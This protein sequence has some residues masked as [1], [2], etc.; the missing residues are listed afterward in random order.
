MFITATVFAG[1]KDLDKIYMTA[2]AFYLGHF[3]SSQFTDVLDRFDEQRE[4]MEHPFSDNTL[5]WNIRWFDM[6]LGFYRG[7]LSYEMGWH[8]R[9]YYLDAWNLFDTGSNDP[10]AQ[11]LRVKMTAVYSGVGL[12]LLHGFVTPAVTLEAGKLQISTYA[13][14]KSLKY[15]RRGRRFYDH[16]DEGVDEWMAYLNL[17]V[18]IM[19]PT[20][21]EEVFIKVEPYYLMGM[22]TV[23]LAR[24]SQSLTPGLPVDNPNWKPEVYGVMISYAIFF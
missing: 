2:P 3:P 5:T 13:E 18:K 8:T 19:I 6:G 14:D 10:T 21:W 20:G 7:F 4:W 24:L 17:S 16:L 1:P 23:S 15:S 11:F 12:P 9:R 22:K